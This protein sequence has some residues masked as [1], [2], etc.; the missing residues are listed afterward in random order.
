MC[1][2]LKY[3]LFHQLRGFCLFA[4][5]VFIAPSAFR[6]SWPGTVSPQDPGLLLPFSSFAKIEGGC[7]QD[8]DESGSLWC[9]HT[10]LHFPG[11][12]N[13]SF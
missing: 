9:L 11:I 8:H 10:S 5:F 1:L 12:W 4:Q 7:S 13:S 3:V 6:E 2:C